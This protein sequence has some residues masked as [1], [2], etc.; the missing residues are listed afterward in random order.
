[1]AKE[2][3]EEQ[4]KERDKDIEEICRTGLSLMEGLLKNKIENVVA[5]GK[6]AKGWKLLVEA[7]ERKGVPDT[8]DILGRYEVEMDA[9]GKLLAYKQVMLRRR[10]D[11]QVEAK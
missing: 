4:K 6:D 5:V 11:L 10:G 7:L 3:E 2:V 1:M 8:A 9:K